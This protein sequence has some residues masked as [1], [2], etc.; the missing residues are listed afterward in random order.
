MR[1]IVTL[2]II[3]RYLAKEVLLTTLTVTVLLVL[4]FLS[5]Q[6]LR[7]LSKIAAGKLA[8]S[9][10]L[11]VIW[12]EVPILLGYLLPVGLFLGILLAYGRLYADNE[13][14][15]L[16]ACGMG[17][18]RILSFTLI[19]SIPI[20]ILVA[21][22]VMVVA[23]NLI[24]V[25]ENNLSQ[26]GATLLLQT[27]IPGRFQTLQDNNQVAYVENITRDRKTLN[28]VF[29]AQYTKPDPRH[30]AWH[31]VITTAQYAN[32]QYDP[33]Q[34]KHILVAHHG[35]RYDGIAGVNNYDITQFGSYG[36]IVPQNEQ[37]NDFK[38]KALSTQKIWQEKHNNLT[39]E[40]EW[41]WR[42]ALPFSMI[43]LILL[44]V[45]ISYVKPRQGKFAKI[46]PATLIYII[47]ANMLFVCRDWI[48][49]QTIP[50]G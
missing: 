6:F 22:L 36:V 15:V 41:Q 30:P 17:Q 14:T 35:Y 40:A 39:Y 42:L 21:V 1:S 18:G 47:Y 31:W 34:N 4:I 26:Q 38:V 27:I 25:Q 13:M 3:F 44:G 46:L 9:L 5:N 24:R 20:I 43:L 45:P 10:L 8:F 16:R 12:L 50:V 28:H 19:F 32:Q 29:L 37:Q 2:V 48:T 11:H 23:P 49:N 7:L 33:L